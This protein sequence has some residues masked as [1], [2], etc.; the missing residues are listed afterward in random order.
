M[1]S[2]TE[3]GIT[4]AV[5]TETAAKTPMEVWQVCGIKFRV[6]TLPP[7]LGGAIRLS[8][9]MTASETSPKPINGPAARRNASN[10]PFK[11]GIRVQLRNALVAHPSDGGSRDDHDRHAVIDASDPNTLDHVAGMAGGQQRAANGSGNVDEIHQDRRA[12]SGHAI[13]AGLAMVGN[14][15]AGGR[16]HQFGDGTSV[17]RLDPDGGGSLPAL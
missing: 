3:P 16:D 1:P 13:N 5:A 6:L 4:Q 10:R 15:L 8:L 17:E 7:F 12:G 9:G 11:S 2:A 14:G